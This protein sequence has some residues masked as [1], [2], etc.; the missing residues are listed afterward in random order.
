MQKGTTSR[1]LRLSFAEK[2]ED[3]TTDRELGLERRTEL[4]NM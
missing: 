4:I 3:T 1:V 2:C